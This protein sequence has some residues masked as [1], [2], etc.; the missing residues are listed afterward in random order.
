MKEPQDVI[1]GPLVTEKLATMN[2]RANVV[3]F[4]VDPDANKIDIRRA[5]ET[6]WKVRVEH[7]RTQN[8]L[9]KVKRMGRFFGRRPSWKKAIVTL[10]EGDSI[11][12]FS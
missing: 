11:P 2:E 10:A 1:M 6:L 5:V 12:E 3:A 7:V 9:G 4:R 8:H